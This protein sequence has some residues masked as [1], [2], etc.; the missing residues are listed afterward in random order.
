M[1]NIK[2]FNFNNLDLKL[3]K[4]D[5]WDFYLANDD[6]GGSCDTL[7]SGGCSVVWYDFNN[8]DI[9]VDNNKETI[10]SLYSWTGATNTGYTLNTVGLTGIDNGLI[11]FDKASGDTTNQALLSALTESMLVIPSGDTR[12]VM[13]RVTGTT[14]N[15]NYYIDYSIDV[16]S[17]A[18]VKFLGGFYQGYYKLDGTTYELLPTRVENSWSTE[19]WIKPEFSGE[20]S[21]TTLNDLHPNNKGIFFYMGTRAENKFW[22]QWDGAD[23]GCTSNCTTSA[24]T[25]GETV[26]EW[27]TIPKESDITIVGDYGIGIPLSP[28]Q[29][30]IDLITNEFLIYGRGSGDIDFSRY[31]AATGTIEINNLDGDTTSGCTSGCSCRR[32]SGPD[33]GLA[34][35]R[36]GQYDGNGIAVGRTRSYLSNEN[37]PFLIYGR[38]SLSG[39]CAHTFSR[40]GGPDDG[41][42]NKTVR[43]FS[44]RTAPLETMDYNLDIIDNAIGFRIKDDG[45][46]GYRL[47][48]V[49]GK[50]ETINGERVNITG[51]TIEENYSPSGVVKT[52]EW[53]YVVLKFV[54]DYKSE[55]DLTTAHQRKGK[56][57]VY[58]NGKLKKVFDNF[59]EFI[60]R[61][62]DEHKS[63]QVGV[64]FN[65]S[66]GGGTQGLLES[67]TFDG[68]D[69][70]DRNL[71][72][73]TNFAGSFIGSISQFKFNICELKY[74]NIIQNFNHGVPRY[75]PLDTNL[76]LQE[77]GDY[78]LQEDGYGLL[79]N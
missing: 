40:C 58:V 1:G 54:T 31:T 61:R 26:S 51:V 6:R 48:T 18:Y 71:P 43:S 9:Y 17:G 46:I 35:L 74:C 30:E 25:S 41:F 2:N 76:L 68:L 56:L 62:L 79:W 69:P 3:S 10:Y 27:C 53:S 72:I 42:G 50:C 28:P 33:D 4:S 23:T 70:N 5:Y 64:P 55:C 21:G 12:F 65:F 52:D 34:Y 19:F 78:L 59:S 15:L 20:T 73:E 13:S 75:R 11:T 44:G 39:G 66:L 37:N 29:M 38:A 49:T 67:Q 7:L 47:L 14:S 24:C 57:M 32:C 16:V 63:K 60:A 22:N 8:T 45:S 77:D 36:A